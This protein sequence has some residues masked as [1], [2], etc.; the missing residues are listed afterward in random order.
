M[1]GRSQENSSSW[2]NHSRQ[3]AGSE[4][5]RNDG[6]DLLVQ[7]VFRIEQKYEFGKQLFFDEK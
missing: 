7:K 3:I 6:A 4:S 2:A 5:H 1:T